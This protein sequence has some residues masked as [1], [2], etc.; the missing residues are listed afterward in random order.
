MLAG[1]ACSP[2]YWPAVLA[3]VS[4]STTAR[5]SLTV[6]AAAATG[7]GGGRPM[8]WSAR[9]GPHRLQACRASHQLRQCDTTG[10]L[11]LDDPER[12]EQVGH[13]VELLGRTGHEDRERL[14]P[15][16]LDPR[17]EDRC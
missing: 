11:E 7:G 13:R 5:T 1:I 8:E 2:L 3:G 4:V 17:L 6:A 14:Q 15:D 16:V 12:L 10:A 9:A